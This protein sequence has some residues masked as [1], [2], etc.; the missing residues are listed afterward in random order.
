MKPPF[1]WD[2]YSDQP[3]LLRDRAYK[4]KMRKTQRM[5]YVRML[6]TS[7]LVLPAAILAMPFCKGKK[8]NPR[9][10]F[11]MGV[12][13]DRGEEQFL[14]IQELGVQHVLV[15]IPLWEM[16][17]ID[18]YVA[19]VRRFYEQGCMILLNV[20]QD[21][22]HIE[23]HDLLRE[24]LALIFAAMHSYVKEYQ[25]GNAI[26][27]SKWGFFSADEYLHFYQVAQ[28][29]RDESYPSLK[30]LG[31]AVIDFEYHYT[32]R[33]LF[34]FSGLRFDRI[35]ALL[36]V[37]RR[38]APENRQYGFNTQLKIALLY[39]MARM[40]RLVRNPNAYITEVNWPLSGTA[41]YAPTSETECVDPN[42]YAD[43]M[44]AYFETALDSGKVARVYWHQLVAP[45]YGLVDNRDGEMK[46]YPAY[47][48]F[49][50]LIQQ[51]NR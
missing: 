18:E 35:S 42:V 32:A 25:I 29:L 17:R 23:D 40:S 48:V 38:G 10:F 4:K 51:V 44:R 24:D 30:L 26:N 31:P 11:G 7:L 12:S 27:R 36:Y 50:D 13:L 34:N 43:Y 45:G 9:D 47:Q 33:A 22:E 2:P 20:L 49:K 15:R 16:H 6:L 19:F 39:S 46:K 21:R 37:D 14:L 8:P 3:A 41:P 28:A 5:A 1:S